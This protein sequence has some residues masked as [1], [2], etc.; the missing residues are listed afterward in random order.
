MRERL[1][2]NVGTR[3]R[4]ARG[5]RTPARPAA[6]LGRGASGARAAAPAVRRSARPAP[7]Q[8][9]D[10]AW[11]GLIGFTAVLFLRPQDQVPPLGM[12]HLAELFAIVG[13]G[14]M[15]VA[16][17]TRGLSAAPFTPEIGGLLAFGAAMLVGIPFSFWPGGSAKEFIDVYLKVLVIVV[18]MIHCLD[19]PE[20]LDQFTSLIVVCSG[21]VAVRSLFDYSRGVHLVED[22]RLGGAVGG[23]FGNPNDLALNMVVFLPFALAAAFKPGST[24]KRLVAAFCTLVMV[25]TLVLTRSRGGFLGLGAMLV[26][27]VMGSE[28]VGGVT[29]VSVLLAFLTARY[30][31][32]GGSVTE[33]RGL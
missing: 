11:R 14:G 1:T 25:A 33:V 21:F 26:L 28:M 9:T 16:R 3:A 27:L 17:V 32:T 31:H 19:R 22:G 20:R 10:W 4:A 23:I 18:L 13:L 2:F 6:A 15:I 12:L 8:A 29:N 24:P 30:F 5:P 7:A